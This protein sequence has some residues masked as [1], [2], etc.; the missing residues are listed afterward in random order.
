LLSGAPT[1]DSTFAKLTLPKLPP[2]GPVIVQ[3]VSPVG[4]FTVSLPSPPSKLTARPAETTE[5][6]TVSVSAPAPPVIVRRL[7]W[8]S[9]CAETA[10]STVTVTSPPE[11]A[12]V[13]L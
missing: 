9:A 11:T 7:T 8:A 12:T 5:A 3:A 2:P 10:P 4:P 1:S 13:T 6:S